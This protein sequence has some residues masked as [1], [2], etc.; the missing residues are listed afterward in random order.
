MK[1]VNSIKN[2]LAVLLMALAITSC[3]SN[4]KGEIDLPLPEPK[5]DPVPEAAFVFNHPCALYTGEDFARVRKSLEDGTAPQPVKDEFKALQQNNYTNGNYGVVTHEHQQIVR[6][7]AKGTIEGSEN[8]GDAMRDAAAAHQFGML[9]QL[10]GN[11]EYAQK[12]ITILNAWAGKCTAVTSNDSNHKLA[13]GCQGFTFALA[14]ELLRD[15]KG[16]TESKFIIYKRWMMSV[17]ATKNLEFLEKHQN[18]N[19]GA[20]HYWSNWDLVNLCSYLQIGILTEDEK[21][22]NYVIEYFMKSG[23]GTGALNNLVLAEHNDP[24]GSGE[25]ICQAQESGRDQGHAHMAAMVAGQLAQCAWALY[26]SNPTKNLDFYG[27][28]D[29]ALLKMFEYVAL[30]NLRN[31]TDNSNATGTWLI[32]AAEINAKAWTA[33]GPWCSGGDNHEACHVHTLFADDSG[34]GNVRPGWEC[35]YQHYKAQGVTSTKYVKMFADKLR[36]ECGVGDSR[37]GGNSGAFDQ[38]GWGTLMSYK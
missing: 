5:P 37:Y 21:I 4:E 36:P 2:V 38:I 26:Q 8:Y 19:C 29:N 6:G 15:Y 3:Q 34:R 25:K 32:S 1:V 10:T 22:V 20:K 30:T 23:I 28:K 13:A 27:A 16:W 12:G 35:I 17:F 14:G 33:V 18:T 11:E 9:W 31:G 7:D 24:L